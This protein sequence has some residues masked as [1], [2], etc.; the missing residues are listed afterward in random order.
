MLADDGN[1]LSRSQ[2]VERNPVVIEGS[3]E[4]LDDDLL[5]A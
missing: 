2:V 1:R 5:T 4:V 3:V